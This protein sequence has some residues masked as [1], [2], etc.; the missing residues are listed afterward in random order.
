MARFFLL[1][2]SVEL[3]SKNMHV[4]VV[5]VKSCKHAIQK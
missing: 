3:P 2:M 4:Y 1:G 5:Q